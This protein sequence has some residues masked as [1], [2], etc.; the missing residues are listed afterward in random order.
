MATYRER[1]LSPEVLATA[2]E[3]AGTVTSPLIPW[4][5]CGATMTAALGVSTFTYLPYCFF[6]LLN[7]LLTRN[8]EAD[9]YVMATD[10]DGVYLDWG[11]PH[12][13]RIVEMTADEL[14]QYDFAAGSMGPKVEV[15]IAFVR[16][17]GRRAAIG[18]LTESSS[19]ASR[20]PF[21]LFHLI[22][23]QMTALVAFIVTFLGAAVF[24]ILG[25]IPFTPFQIL[26]INFLVQV[27]IAVALGFDI[28][29]GDLMERKPRPLNQPILTLAQWVRIA[30]I[31]T[32]MG[33]FTLYL[34]ARAEPTSPMLAATMGFVVFSLLNIAIA[35]IS[36]SETASAFNRDIL[37][38]RHQL[39][40]YA[41]AALMLFLPTALGFLQD[42][43]G[44]QSLT[45]AQWVTCLGF[46]LALVLVDEIIKFFMRRQRKE[47]NL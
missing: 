30:F 37:H 35:L 27:P 13:R 6:N 4:N 38:D 19:R 18:S 16:N 44:L 23:F 40:L 41:L 17:T 11:T 15:A 2:V 46:A 1:G 26:W 45:F 43:L 32:L 9:L 36:R 47:A 21:R 20:W 34:E 42:F 22:R 39:G 5:S 12:Q 29:A 3:N 33:G 24:F 31:G 28:P 10:V 7:P 8:I 14:A 25:G